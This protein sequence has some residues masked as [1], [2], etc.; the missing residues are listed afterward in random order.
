MDLREPGLPVQWATYERRPVGRGGARRSPSRRRCYRATRPFIPEIRSGPRSIWSGVRPNPR[1]SERVSIDRSW[2]LGGI[3]G[4]G[5]DTSGHRWKI[6]LANRR[7]RVPTSQPAG[8]PQQLKVP[9]THQASVDGWHLLGLLGVRFVGGTFRHLLGL[10]GVRFV[11]GTFRQF[12]GGTFRHRASEASVDGWHLVGVL[13]VDTSSGCNWWV[14]RMDCS[15]V[16]P[17]ESAGVFDW[18]SDV[19][20]GA[21]G[22]ESCLKFRELVSLACIRRPNPTVVFTSLPARQDQK[23]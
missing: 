23:G 10:L 1:P 18:D 4:M 6:F 2:S 14:A 13:L 12:V 9:P 19:V 16:A 21:S 15:W 17:I 11:G 22:N 8:L 7:F 5:C 3:L 20:V